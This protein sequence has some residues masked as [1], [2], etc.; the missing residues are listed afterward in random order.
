M[1]ALA[2][3]LLA[4][5]IAGASAYLA[6]FSST[7]DL[8][9][10][11]FGERCERFMAG[12]AGPFESSWDMTSTGVEVSCQDRNDG[13]AAR[14]VESHLWPLYLWEAVG[15][16]V[17]VAVASYLLVTWFLKSIGR[18]L[19]AARGEPL[20][21]QGESDQE[22]SSIPRRLRRYLSTKRSRVHLV[23]LVVATATLT[24][25]HLITMSRASFPYQRSLFVSPLGVPAAAAAGTLTIMIL[26]CRAQSRSGKSRIKSNS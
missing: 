26:Q 11:G 17:L 4:I 21:L 18:R 16:P 10:D 12:R 13:A 2:L 24:A 22:A 25:D 23:G 9:G 19:K 3:R 20:P 7:F 6:L 8:V 15:Q 1:A 14:F 5:V